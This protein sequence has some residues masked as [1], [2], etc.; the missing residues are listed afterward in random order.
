[1]YKFS[2]LFSRKKTQKFEPD[3]LIA[4]DPSRSGSH[5]NTRDHNCCTCY[6]YKTCTVTESLERLFDGHI[7]HILSV[8]TRDSQSGFPTEEEMHGL[9]S[10]LG[11][12]ASGLMEHWVTSSPGEYQHSDTSFY[13]QRMKAA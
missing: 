6:S 13:C 10:H 5:F 8:S 3:L 1:M 9:L 4:K 12:D 11:F 2:K 7:Y